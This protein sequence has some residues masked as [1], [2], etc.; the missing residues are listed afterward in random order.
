MATQSYLQRV[1]GSTPSPD[2]GNLQA[3]LAKGLPVRPTLF[4]F[5]L[6]GRLYKRLSAV[7]G[8]P[9]DDDYG[10]ARVLTA[11]FYQ[12]GYDYVTFKPPAFCFPAGA[13]GHEQTL[14][15]NEGALITNRE[16]FESY[17]WIHPDDC[18]DYDMLERISSDL[19]DGM[20]VVLYG[21]GGVLEN[22][23]R[24]AG[25]DN[26]CFMIADDP[27]LTQELFDAVGSR[28]VRHYELGCEHE[29][30]GAA[31]SNDDW[32]FKTQPMLSPAD[33]RTF[34]FPWHKRIVEAI[35]N[36]GDLAILHSCGNASEIMEDIIEDMG[37]DGKH[38][39]EDTIEPVESIYEDYQERIAILGGVDLDFLVRSEPDK[40]Y[41]RARALLEQSADT[42]GYALGTGNSVPEYVPDENYCAMIWAALEVRA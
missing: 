22:V 19:P 9:T 30:V 3:V 25:Y 39:Y 12:A 2:F 8:L 35:H 15:L 10:M 20:K 28:L 17:E 40:V 29:S 26:L 34:V 13:R 37:F 18:G 38:S 42:G 27:E 11:A 21:P 1:L 5:F 16:T 33:L 36:A 24:L 14:S 23:I 4:E 41:R 32:G 6:N 7:S 31:I